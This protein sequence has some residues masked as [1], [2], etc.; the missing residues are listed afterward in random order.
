VSGSLEGDRKRQEK[1]SD[2][3]EKFGSRE[4]R[5]IRQCGKCPHALRV[6][7]GSIRRKR[8]KYQVGKREG[9]LGGGE[10]GTGASSVRTTTLLKR[11][12]T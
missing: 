8:G 7:E 6:R 3:R 1:E 11:L 9:A 2:S 5:A 10:R 12:W 4:G